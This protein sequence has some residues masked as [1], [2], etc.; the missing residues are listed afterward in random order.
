MLQRN[1][2]DKNPTT[3]L[4]KKSICSS[5]EERTK[6]FS[7]FLSVFW[8]H[9]EPSS[10]RPAFVKQISETCLGGAESCSSSVLSSYVPI[11]L[12]VLEL[13]SLLTP[14]WNSKLGQWL[15]LG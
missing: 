8:Q 3:P 5:K 2:W 6:R 7:P 4:Q 10:P 13:A 14:S 11:T 12:V 15:I 1:V 9:I